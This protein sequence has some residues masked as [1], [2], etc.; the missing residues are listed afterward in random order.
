V[1]EVVVSEISVVDITLVC[2][3]LTGVDVVISVLLAVVDV[4][5]RV[6]VDVEVATAVV[7]FVVEVVD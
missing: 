1:L 7:G 4:C 6:D 5:V 2:V 3:V